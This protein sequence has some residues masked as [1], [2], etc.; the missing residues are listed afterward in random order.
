MLPNHLTQQISVSNNDSKKNF[1]DLKPSQKQQPSF[2]KLKD[3]QISNV[4]ESEA[5]VPFFT[6]KNDTNKMTQAGDLDLQLLNSNDA[7]MV[8]EPPKV[9]QTLTERIQG[10]QDMNMQF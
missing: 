2:F 3:D 4:A 10:I 5:N 7:K 9:P 1:L 8:S 6:L